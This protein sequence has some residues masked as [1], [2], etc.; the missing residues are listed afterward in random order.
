MALKIWKLKSSFGEAVKFYLRKF[1][2]KH[3]FTSKT[4]KNSQLPSRYVTDLCRFLSRFHSH[5][6]YVMLCYIFFMYYIFLVMLYVLYFIWRPIHIPNILNKY[7]AGSVI[8]MRFLKRAREADSRISIG[9]C[10]QSWLARYSFE[11]VFQ[12]TRICLEDVKISETVH[13]FC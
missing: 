4:L 7:F 3:N 5:S 10:C 1:S 13:I 12:W 11:S 9:T 8:L 6:Y 2:E